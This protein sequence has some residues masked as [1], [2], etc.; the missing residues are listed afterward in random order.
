MSIFMY[1]IP[2]Y[3]FKWLFV[4]KIYIIYEYRIITIGLLGNKCPFYI[5][6]FFFKFYNWHFQTFI[7]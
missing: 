6:D 1:R 3:T 2:I 5:F 7:Q 4:A